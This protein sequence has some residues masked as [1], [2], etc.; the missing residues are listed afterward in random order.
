MI[1]QMISLNPSDR[2]TFDNLL[3]ISRGTVFP[4]SFYSF[5]HNYVSSINE[6]SS[7]LT[8][9]M[10]PTAQPV[11]T[12]TTAAMRPGST[13]ATGTGTNA[14]HGPD[15]LPSDSDHR[16]ERLWADYESVV[17]YLI[18]DT[19]QDTAMDIRVDYSPPPLTSKPFQDVLPVELNIPNRDSKL[20]GVP[21]GGRRAALRGILLN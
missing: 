5:L 19:S 4:E 20:R 2:S 11:S 6:L 10:P 8:V 16:M 7:I 17:P 14:D 13:I 9:N 21:D 15:N 3:H 12:P 1:K 18:E